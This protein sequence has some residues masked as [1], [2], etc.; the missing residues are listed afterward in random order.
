MG[1]EEEGT[2]TIWA[3]DLPIY[4]QIVDRILAH[5]LDGT[6]QEGA[7]LPS[8]RQLAGQFGVNSLTVAKALNTLTQLGVTEKRRGVGLVL[9]VGARGVIMVQERRKFLEEEWPGLRQRIQR[10][11]LDI[12]A[13]LGDAPC[14]PT[15]A[16]SEAAGLIHSAISP[17]GSGATPAPPEARRPVAP[18]PATP[19]GLPGRAKRTGSR[20]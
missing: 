9:K 5:I 10:M 3:D 7:Y 18:R 14:Q 12:A 6:Y 16:P 13:L 19:A 11:G 8:V 1:H 20:A 4:R 17:P 15:P 2:A